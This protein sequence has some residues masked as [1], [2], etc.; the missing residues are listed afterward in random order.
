MTFTEKQ[1]KEHREKF[2]NECRQK[3]WGASCHAD[4]V[5]KG[6]D[7]IVAFYQKLS[8]EDRDLEAEIK[9]IETSADYHTV[10]NRNKRKALQGRRNEIAKVM[11]S[12]AADMQ[13]G[14]KALNSRDSRH[15]ICHKSQNFG[16]GEP[17][18]EFALVCASGS[19]L[20]LLAEATLAVSPSFQ[21]HAS[22]CSASCKLASMLWYKP[23]SGRW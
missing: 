1:Q 4:W 21:L 16:Q 23:P 6:L 2:I 17:P 19:D 10:E 14:Q 22:A 18:F 8:D 13:Q 20:E 5:S 12:I 7:T 11:S 15:G 9:A 3:A